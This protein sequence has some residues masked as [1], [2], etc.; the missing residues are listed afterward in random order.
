MKHCNSSLGVLLAVGLGIAPTALSQTTR[1]SVSTGGVQANAECT[2][3]A[4]SA[5]GRFVAF[6]S[7]ATNLAPGATTG[8]R[9]IYRHDRLSGITVLVSQSTAGQAAAA[10]CNSLSISADGRYIAFH[11]TASN[12]IPGDINNA[13]DVFLRDVFLGLTS[14][15]S[16]ANGGAEGNGASINPSISDDGTVI[17]FNSSA[18]NL[19]AG[20][21]NGAADIFVRNLTTG[22]TT[23]ATIGPGGVQTT[24]L[25]GGPMLS[26]NGQIVAFASTANNLVA[27]DTN[28]ARDVFVR[29][30]TAGVT[31][32]VSVAT[33]GG[34]ANGA[35]GTDFSISRDGRFVAF[36]TSATNL[37][38]LDP[39]SQDDIYVRDRQANL[40]TL[41]AVNGAG[42]HANG[43]S[44]LGRI[45]GDGI[46]IAFSS[47]AN[48][49]VTPEP[50]PWTDVFV[51]NRVTGQ[52]S[53]AT[54]S[55]T[56]TSS[57]SG[58]T[59]LSGLSYDGRYVVFE[60][61][62]TDLVSGDTNG[63]RD[64]FVTDMVTG[65]PAPVITAHPTTQSSCLE[66][67]MT[68]TVAANSGGILSYQ[69][70]KNGSSI[71]GATSDTYTINS[72]AAGDA[73]AYN[74]I[75]SDGCGQVYSDHALAKIGL[76]IISQPP[77]TT[78]V[79]PGAP[80]TLS[81]AAGGAEPIS[82]QWF[83]DAG[84]ISGATS[85]QFQV[86][87]ASSLNAG[88]YTVLVSNA[89][90]SQSSTNATVSVRTPVT[91]QTHPQN[92]NPCAGQ[93]GTFTVV[94][95]GTTPLS[96]QWR[97]NG[98]N[99]AGAT[100]ATLVRS[101]IPGNLGNYDV[102]V[103]NA[104]GSVTS[105]V[106]T[107][108]LNTA[109]MPIW[110]T[111]PVSQF[112]CT[113]DS[114]TF[115]GVVA[116]P[117]LTYQWKEFH[118]PSSSYVNIPGATS[119]S[120]TFNN[121]TVA[122]NGRAF[123]LVVSNFC[124]TIS[125]GSPEIRVELYPVSITQQPTQQVVCTNNTLTMPA[126]AIVS[127]PYT[128]TWRHNGTPIPGANSLTLVIPA[129]QPN[130][131]GLYDFTISTLCSSADSDVVS[132]AVTPYDPPV[133]TLQ[134]VSQSVCPGAGIQFT[135]S[136]TGGA[137][138]GYQWRRSGQP[139]PGATGTTLVINP[140]TVS[141]A[142]SY[143][144]AVTNGCGVAISQSADL[145]VS[146][147]PVIIRHP[148]GR[149][150]GLGE[151]VQLFVEAS[152]VGLTY[153]WKKGNVAIP[154]AT[155]PTLEFESA[156]P[157]DAGSYTVEV[158][159][160]CGGSVQSNAA[161]LAVGTAAPV[162]LIS[163][164]ESGNPAGQDI[165]RTVCSGDGRFVAF[166]TTAHLRP[167][168]YGN[169]QQHVYV[170]DRLLG[171]TIIAD[172]ANDDVNGDCDFVSRGS[173]WIAFESEATNLVAQDGNDNRDI[174]LA[175]GSVRTDVT[176]ISRHPSG[177]EA[178]GPSRRPVV[179]EDGLFVA[180]ESDATNLVAGDTNNAT[181]V[182]LRDRLSG[183]L[184]RI[185]NAVG[186]G[187]TNGSSRGA[188]ISSNG[189]YVA[190]VSEASN[191]VAD[192]A[193]GATDVFVYDRIGGAITRVSTDSTGV[194]ANA[195]SL[196][197]HIAAGGRYVA[198]TTG[199]TNL[200]ANDNNAR[201]DVYI[202]D[203]QTGASSLASLATGSTQANED[204]R[205]PYLSTTGQWLAFVTRS[206]TLVA[207]DT[208]HFDKVYLRNMA[209]GT[210][211]LVTADLNG[212]EANGDSD[213]PCIG[214][215]VS[216]T[217]PVY[218]QS[219]ASNLTESSDP[220][221]NCRTDIFRRYGG[222]GTTTR[223]NRTVAGQQ[224]NGHAIH[225]S[226]HAPDNE[227]TFISNAQNLIN[228]GP[229]LF[230]NVY[231]SSATTGLGAT[232][233]SIGWLSNGMA[234]IDSQVLSGDGRYL[235]FAS[236]A[237]NLRS[238]LTGASNVYVRDL[239]SGELRIANV[240]PAGA[241]SNNP[242]Y[243]PAISSNGRF[244][245]YQS[246][247]TNLVPIDANGTKSDVFRYDRQT[248][249]VDIASVS[250]S[251]D[252]GD[253]HSGPGVVSDDGR[254]IAYESSAGNLAAGDTN[255]RKDV[256][257]RDMTAGTTSRVS[258]GTSGA[259]ASQD[260]I[261]VSLSSDG[262]FVSFESAAILVSGDSNSQADIFIRD[263]QAGQTIRAS[264]GFTGN[265]AN[266]ES[267]RSS[268]SG[269]GQFVAFFSAATDLMSGISGVQVYLRNLG[270]GEIRV[271][272]LT[273]QSTLPAQDSS[274][275][276]LSGD[277]RYVAFCSRG[278]LVSADTN[279]KT[280]AYLS[281]MYVCASPSIIT[282]PQG[283]TYPS[284][285]PI[286]LTVLAG[287]TLPLTYQW[288][289]EGV[290][291]PGQTSSSLTIAWPIASDTGNYDVV[292]TNPCGNATSTAALVL[293]EEC[294]VVTTMVSLSNAG[295][296][297]GQATYP[298]FSY[299]GRFM[300]INAEQG[301][302]VPLNSFGPSVYV[303]DRLTGSVAPMNIK[304]TGT[305]PTTGSSRE[306]TLSDD[307]RFVAFL[308]DSPHL[309]SGD[310][311]NAQD[312]FV[313]DRDPDG[314]G[315]FDEPGAV[316]TRVSVSTGGGQTGG[317]IYPQ[318]SGNG[319]YVIFQSSA[320]DVD[321]NPPPLEV[322]SQHIYRHDRVTNTTVRV[323]C[324]A[325]G[326]PADAPCFLGSMS[327]D[328]RYVAFRSGASNLATVSILSDH[329]FV[330]DMQAGDVTLAGL[331]T[332]GAE[333][334]GQFDELVISANGR[335]VAF[336][337]PAPFDPADTNNVKDVY[338]R[339]L[340]TA[341]TTRETV[342]SNGAVAN[343]QTTNVD[344][345][346]DGRYLAFYSD[347]SNLASGDLNGFRDLIIKDR[348]TGQFTIGSVGLGG[349]AANDQTGVPTGLTDPRGIAISPQGNCAAFFSEASNLI[350]STISNSS[351]MYVRD[352]VA[353]QTTRA[354]LGGAGVP[355]NDV[356][357]RPTVS[358]DGRFVAYK[359]ESSNLVAGGVN[360]AGDIFL[361]DVL[362]A[363]TIRVNLLPGGEQMSSG[364]S[365]GNPV[366]SRN[367]RF[368]AYGCSA[369][370]AADD[371]NQRDDI[372]VYDAESGISVVVS[373]SSSGAQGNQSS[374]GPIALSEN[375][376]FVAFESGATNL[377]AGDT[378]GNTD[379]FLRDRDPDGDGIF[380]QAGAVTVRAS[381][382]ADGSQLPAGAGS[383]GVSDNG[384]FVVFR[385]LASQ[386]VS[387]D[388]NNVADIFLRD[389]QLGTT[390]R[391]SIATDGTQANAHCD[392]PVISGDGRYVAFASL[393]TT[394][395]SGPTGVHNHVF[396][397]DTLAG[398]TSIVSLDSNGL[399]GN[400]HAA[401]PAISTDGRF[402]AWD[403]YA[404]NLV[405]GDTNSFKD[406][407]VRDRVTAITSRISVSSSG[408]QADD[409]SMQV[410]MSGDGSYFVFAS[411][412]GTLTDVYSNGTN[413]HLHQ[414]GTCTQPYFL[415]GPDGAI[416]PAAQ[417]VFLDVIVG[418]HSAPELQWRRNGVA[419]P[420][421]T[422]RMLVIAALS[423]SNEGIYDVVATNELGSA[424][425]SQA[426][427]FLL[428]PGDLNCDD[429]IDLLDL[430][431]FI[432]ALIDP[433]AFAQAYP[434]CGLQPADTNGDGQINGRDVV[435]IVELLTAP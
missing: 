76:A 143:D 370:I 248:G 220:D 172:G 74:V 435:G 111:P 331:S 154:G 156:S 178:D 51:R 247:A 95:T 44:T 385:S 304:P 324:S 374:E 263:T 2:H 420:G 25:S 390:T 169:N 354:G 159:S 379:V 267:I 160:A 158:F 9:Q 46:T 66:G 195:A 410:G 176:C 11:T 368:V 411:E 36:Q 119:S 276:V 29:D 350:A 392:S 419:I 171:K 180:F 184:V 315:F 64:I 397:R 211:A 217:P 252:Q 322:N 153:Q 168:P 430:S 61:T 376:R 393:S 58:S 45:S 231:S 383:P 413:I 281:D 298:A 26:G 407:F 338:I 380:D 402:I 73:A 37:D 326:V 182:F 137:G 256:Y 312:V 341:T 216:G 75:V 328:G 227:L 238:G 297:G 81:V 286:V 381:V 274:F 108:T 110:I 166:T 255:A 157:G 94:A 375:G 149:A 207:G 404:T 1:V 313:R 189:Q 353:G 240:N 210:T 86:A 318:I 249:A 209:A 146:G 125:S 188:S 417:P 114:V 41:E 117:G 424:T 147:L 32:R 284:T 129:M 269:D 96:Y 391:V 142:C 162:T 27:V 291:L 253:D 259:Q 34:Q 433:V 296:S 355:G 155:Q 319:R 388:T 418:G 48:N 224:S 123:I 145:N 246:S 201:I 371:T 22:V 229:T 261:R 8:S 170:R 275:P 412:A 163:I 152:G 99:L 23:R 194:E 62:A 243:S 359:S 173:N 118:Q 251:G 105:N 236:M 127:L 317:G 292:V 104:C 88:V 193:N 408:T 294:P 97:F 333:I 19:V 57:T 432:L 196:E 31:E 235:T 423:L 192:D 60:S 358:N 282:P 150:V 213:Y 138:L 266:S 254:F 289:K 131:S 422:Q 332:T 222:S 130:D 98:S 323:S 52:I 434:L 309:V 234:L 394:L 77:A 280:D 165:D 366:M 342:A 6:A 30:L 43:V 308:S 33:G 151:A 226:V 53:R 55:T 181:D 416:V 15:V 16:L 283:G 265:A 258:L 401:N 271:V 144:V 185:S 109:D 80:L 277:G 337:D 20:D 18:S 183:S 3:P 28:T 132:V 362:A 352:L 92:Q 400:N 335:Y 134:P 242:A 239:I 49:L 212:N 39:N 377:V 330:K 329:L 136:A 290:D 233:R 232:R 303:R 365:A 431:A 316:T 307:G 100:Q 415:A 260:C 273:E 398:T 311:N 72:V 387:G 325:G 38:L 199:A 103:S 50:N 208:T 310:T 300:V 219:Q 5:D 42:Q 340:L 270:T 24:G 71:P 101:P 250:T 139:I 203:R 69:W 7:T 17:A 421:A 10:N 102:V 107:L 357:T 65:C 302:F 79:C 344:I 124:G 82:Y 113:G 287:G 87:S 257:L 268:I 228:W 93:N 363:T 245:L 84:P 336:I 425:S 21:T 351:R 349:A 369:A 205:R 364:A 428:N 386:T 202:K 63:V 378:N 133:I 429:A 56:G 299:D 148:K 191:L 4:V 237:T 13:N 372:V 59:Y 314:N 321:V 78:A 116:G 186:G 164:S 305:F 85:P 135:V 83:K 405:G 382:A 206:S 112:A 90:G 360:P 47:D 306:G 301:S 264:S 343:G 167:D 68:F 35:S 106:A 187:P 177:A 356:S 89:C 279:N 91:I 373:R 320:P 427:V 406:V 120:L 230:F 122:D 396:L 198:F 215:T 367:G 389:R 161:S 67:T 14:R 221:T 140:V 345:S 218:F 200:V 399:L 327:G 197:S 190:F 223:M 347:A 334:P 204:C 126:E 272:S 278:P 54:G 403:S 179:S 361:T 175:N 115:T 244:V 40:T 214:S 241:L 409:D 12:L 414:R 174:F 395:V 426:G 285:Q 346:G 121:V 293:V 262:R 348:Q 295:A 384:R 288:R 128:V 141:D 339:D 70:R 225:P